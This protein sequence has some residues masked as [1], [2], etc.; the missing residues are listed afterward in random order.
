MASD[1]PPPLSIPPR[2]LPHKQTFILLHG[3]GSSGEKFGPVLLDTPISTAPHS[4]SDG[5]ND[6]TPT[7]DP[8]HAGAQKISSTV[9]TLATTFPHARFVFPTAALR[10]A[11]IYRRSR[12]HQWFDNWALDAPPAPSAAVA[13]EREALQ[14]PGLRETTMYLHGLLRAEIAL[15]GG[16][17][18]RVVFGG[19]SQ[20]CAAALVTLLLWEGPPLAGA[21]GMC[22]WLPFAERL[23]EEAGAGG[24]KA[25]N[26]V[27]DTEERPEEADD[28]DDMFDT[29]GEHE[30][31]AAGGGEGYTPAGRALQW[32]RD[33]LELPGPEDA[34]ATESAL[35]H[36]PLFL[37]HGVEDDRVSVDLGRSA[38]A[39]LG[40]LGAQRVVWREYEGLAHWY[41]SQMLQDMVKFLEINTNIDLN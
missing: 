25:G 15:A 40:S 26:D 6:P 31:E 5:T 34:K 11:T 1:Y 7:D 21:V 41:S 37:G 27:D 23:V 2:V 4:S 19:L 16:D 8:G 17:A 36:T 32:F 20:G 35:S 24:G 12:I 3:R 39:C 10:R 14:V 29:G 18:S 38:A 30:A 22:G 13:A 33:E 28:D 9:Q